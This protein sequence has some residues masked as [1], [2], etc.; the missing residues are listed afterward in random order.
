[1]LIFMLSYF[2]YVK[3]YVCILSYYR[4]Q[5]GQLPQ[6]SSRCQYFLRTQHSTFQSH[7]KLEPS[8]WLGMH[9]PH[10]CQLLRNQTEYIGWPLNNKKKWKG[11]TLM[12]LLTL[13]QYYWVIKLTPPN[14]IIE[15]SIHPHLKVHRQQN[16]KHESE[17]L[18]KLVIQHFSAVCLEQSYTYWNQMITL[19]QIC[20][21][22]FTFKYCWRLQLRLVSIVKCCRKEVIA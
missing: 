15:Q 19:K 12:K 21:L 22:I 6:W 20:N 8:K 18:P 17:S 5:E 9:L 16:C 4:R 14:Q 13:V 7:W 3:W 11:T 1:M 2:T 10:C